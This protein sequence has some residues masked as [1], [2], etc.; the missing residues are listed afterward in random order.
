MRSK[1]AGLFQEASWH[2]VAKNSQMS[3]PRCRITY[4]LEVKTVTAAELHQLAAPTNGN[5]QKGVIATAAPAL[6]LGMDP[7]SQ[8]KLVHEPALSEVDDSGAA[9][10]PVD[11]QID[12]HTADLEGALLQAAA[13]TANIQLGARCCAPLTHVDHFHAYV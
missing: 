1:Q 2:T 10:A 13:A 8:L 3:L 12:L 9:Q 6:E 5:A 4:W 11:L 7:Q